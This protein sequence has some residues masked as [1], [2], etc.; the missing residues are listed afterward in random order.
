[1]NRLAWI[2]LAVFVGVPLFWTGSPRA[3]EALASGGTTVAEALADARRMSAELAD[4]LR[5]QL[6]AE[7]GQGGFQGAVEVCSKIGQ[8]IPRQYSE[9]PGVS[10][11]RVSLRYRNP[12]NRPDEYEQQQL[13]K[14]DQLKQTGRLQNDYHEVVPTPAGRELR[15][16]K[17]LLAA[18]MCLNCHGPSEKIPD[19]VNAIL[20]RLYPEDRATGYRSGDVRGAISVRIDVKE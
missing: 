10:I 9:Q 18:D 19:G 2:A 11:R 5:R 6:A 8:D 1:M 20:A 16:M 7:L 17:P 14:F 15:Y 13:E 12:Q 3:P 4:T